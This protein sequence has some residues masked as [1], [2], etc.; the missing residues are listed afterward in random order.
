MLGAAPRQS[1]APWYRYSSD[2]E[3]VRDE[4]EYC[5]D[6]DFL[7]MRGLE[8]DTYRL[9]LRYGGRVTPYFIMDD[10]PS[11]GVHLSSSNQYFESLLALVEFY[12]SP[13][14]LGSRTLPCL[15]SQANSFVVHNM[16]TEHSTH[17]HTD[18]LV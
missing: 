11:S 18:F 12:Q 6:G 4:L 5:D 14:S 7:I 16:V 3:S 8:P 2:L 10:G 1:K 13:Q 9:L 17:V 15:L